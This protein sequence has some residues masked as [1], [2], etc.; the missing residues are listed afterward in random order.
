MATDWTDEHDDDDCDC[1]ECEN[2][3]ALDEDADRATER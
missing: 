1:S 2:L 3:R